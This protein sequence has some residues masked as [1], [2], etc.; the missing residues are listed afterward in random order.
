MSP[1]AHA[2]RDRRTLH[3]HRLALPAT[4]GGLRGVTRDLNASGVYLEVD[5]PVVLGSR[6]ELVVELMSP[7][8]AV[9]CEGR[10]VRVEFDGSRYGVAIAIDD[11]EIE[12]ALDVV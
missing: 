6:A 7:F 12:I 4:L 3:R 1:S 11:V 10:V 2:H 9:R 8:T 5:S